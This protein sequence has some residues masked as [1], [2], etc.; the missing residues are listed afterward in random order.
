MNFV[1][2]KTSVRRSA[3]WDSDNYS[4]LLWWW[5]AREAWRYHDLTMI[6]L[7]VHAGLAK[8][9]H[10]NVYHLIVHVFWRFI[11]TSLLKKIQSSFTGKTWAVLVACFETPHITC[12][13]HIT[14]PTPISRV[15][16]KN[17]WTDQTPYCTFLSKI[18][19]K[20][21]PKQTQT[22]L[23]PDSNQN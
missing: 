17:N 13:L 9:R 12:A 20:R 6:F 11:F 10:S 16:D 18:R 4:L 3:P 23:K 15:Q 5:C 8:F 14:R 19:L 21:N 7:R 2:R 22:R 1:K